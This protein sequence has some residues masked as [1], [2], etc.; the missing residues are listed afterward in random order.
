MPRTASTIGGSASNGVDYV[1]LPV[2]VT[3]PVGERSARITVVPI[4]D[5]DH[6]PL[7]TVVL[8]LT[9]SPTA[10]P[11]TYTIGRPG[12]AAA[13]IVDRSE[14]GADGEHLRDGLFHL[15]LPGIDGFHFR[16]EASDDVANW[17]AICT[18][19]VTEGAIHFVDPD[20]S[21]HSRRFYRVLPE[22]DAGRTL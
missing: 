2:T 7:N 3:I 1:A 12:K 17:A 20:A 11:P 4:E 21:E 6:E 5:S 16:V 13:I 10:I 14:M 19:V 18:N 15:H 8:Q 22:A 9:Q